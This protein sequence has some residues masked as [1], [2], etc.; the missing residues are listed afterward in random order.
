MK[1]AL[2]TLG[3]SQDQRAQIRNVMRQF[4]ESKQSQQPMTRQQMIAQVRGI[5]TPDQQARFQDAMRR[6]RQ[7]MANGQGQYGPQGGPQGQYGPQGGPQ[8]Q[9]GPQGGPDQGQQPGR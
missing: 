8:G 4:R 6:A 9:Y 3:L 1:M 2:R 7:H 5:L